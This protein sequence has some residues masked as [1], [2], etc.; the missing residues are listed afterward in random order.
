MQFIVICEGVPVHV[1]KHS[2]STVKQ[3]IW[4]P[5]PARDT[6]HFFKAGDTNEKI[7]GFLFMLNKEYMDNM[8]SAQLRSAEWPRELKAF[9]RIME[10]AFKSGMDEY[11]DFLRDIKDVIPESAVLVTD[12]GIRSQRVLMFPDSACTTN[13]VI[14]HKEDTLVTRAYTNIL[15]HQTEVLKYDIHSAHQFAIGTGMLGEFYTSQIPNWWYDADSYWATK[16]AREVP[17]C[18]E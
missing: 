3:F 15:E 5:A 16:P 12:K 9:K 14:C 11:S 18:K 2:N 6:A 4:L 8:D 7:Y 13:V 17:Q 1:H 10:M